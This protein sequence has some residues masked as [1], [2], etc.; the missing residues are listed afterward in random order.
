MTSP[1]PD[2]LRGGR[3]G[4]F[5]VWAVGVIIAGGVLIFVW[6]RNR[7]Q[8]AAPTSEPTDTATYY[9]STGDDVYGLPPGAVG[10][11]LAA[12]PLDPAYPV[13]L[14]SNGIPGPITNVQWSRLAF[15][16]LVGKGN[17]PA[18]VERALAKYISKQTLSANEQAIVN[19]AQQTFG[20]PPE[21]LILAEAPAPVP[22]QPTPTPTPTPPSAPAP[23]APSLPSSLTVPANV[24]LY[25]WSQGIEAQ[26]GLGYSVF[27]RIRNQGPLRWKPYSNPAD[28]A[29]YG[30][31]PYFSSTTTVSL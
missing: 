7:N 2:E 16:N 11:Y 22:Q 12:N 14:T 6:V 13:G 15:D 20:A 3:I 10:D 26:Y 31:M 23:A 19:M 25:S 8:S 18:L 1:L 24:D 4:G 29:A 17:D 21:G 5:P 28:T 27:D 9:E 30:N